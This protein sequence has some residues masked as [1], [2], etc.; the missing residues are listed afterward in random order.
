MAQIKLGASL[1]KSVLPELL[2]HFR[3]VG[4]SLE[5]GYRIVSPEVLGIAHQRGENCKLTALSEVLVHAAHKAKR[6]CLPLYK[7]GK[8]PVSLRELAKRHGSVVGEMYSVQSLVE[9]AKDAGFLLSVY[10][11]TN[12]D[13]YIQCLMRLVDRNLP[14]MVFFDM[15]KSDDRYGL[16]YIG[17]GSNEHA[18]VVVGYYKNCFDDPH[19]IVTFWN[20]FFDIDGMELALSAC[21]SLAER[22]KPETFKKVILE[23]ESCWVL[24]DDEIDSDHII[25][26]GIPER[27]APEVK[28]FDEPLKGKIMA[29]TGC[30]RAIPSQCFFKSPSVG[31]PVSSVG[32]P[33]FSYR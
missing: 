10:S 7:D 32:M 15:E 22:R 12:E 3:E 28:T 24:R 23:G 8:N 33:T 5:R 9:T 6:P 16:P 13:E 29:V 30:F 2:M 17:D 18:A 14:P 21:H 11:Y 31:E 25:L 27:S 19:F 4:A 1:G 20:E 26:A